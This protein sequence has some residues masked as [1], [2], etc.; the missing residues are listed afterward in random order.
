MTFDEWYP[1]KSE[2]VNGIGNNPIARYRHE[3]AQAAWHAGQ[4][5]MRDRCIRA[6]SD[7]YAS[8]QREGL[9]SDSA[10]DCAMDAI[11]NLIL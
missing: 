1:Y 5:A 10:H 6:A 2:L 7:E 11:R 9:D 4:E 8:A 3:A